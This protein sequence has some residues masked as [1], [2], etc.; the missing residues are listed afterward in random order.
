MQHLRTRQSKHL[1]DWPNCLRSPHLKLRLRRS[2]SFRQ[3]AS[4]YPNKPCLCPSRR[5]CRTGCSPL[6][7]FGFEL[8]DEAAL[9][10]G[11]ITFRTAPASR[12]A[13]PSVSRPYIRARDHRLAARNS[14]AAAGSI[15]SGSI[16]CR[17]MPK[18]PP[19]QSGSQSRA[20]AYGSRHRPSRVSAKRSTGAA[21][22]RNRSKLVVYAINSSARVSRVGG[23]GR[24][25][26]H[27][28]VANKFLA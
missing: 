24:P 27:L 16:Q 15:Q 19:H 18:P 3:L 11:L 28:A 7:D 1:L 8:V 9:V 25:R 26:A 14:I 4:R 6:S 17:V 10:G 21:T 22:K 13:R 23:T 12:P 5:A 20:G 2:T